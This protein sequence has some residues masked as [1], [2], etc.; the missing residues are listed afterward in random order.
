[1]ETW[2]AVF[3]AEY[4]Q[5]V[6]DAWAQVDIVGGVSGIIGSI[7]SVSSIVGSIIGDIGLVR[8]T[9][10][11]KL[12]INESIGYELEELSIYSVQLH[13]NTQL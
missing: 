13:T 2:D 7:E 11:Q 1:M 5:A 12:A 9:Q 3:L 8:L 4:P 6:E 10:C